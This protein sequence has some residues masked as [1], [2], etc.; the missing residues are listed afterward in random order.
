MIA[1]WHSLGFGLVT[2]GVLAVSSVGLTV[3]FGVIN[4]ANISY[5]QYMTL[6]A[7]FTWDLTNYAHLNIWIAGLLACI[8]VGLVSL[9]IGKAI[10]SQFV[11]RGSPGSHMLLV[12]FATA[13]LLSAIYSV[14]WGPSPRQLDIH[15]LNA[16]H[17]G[18]FLFT[19]VQLYVI[20]LSAGLLIAMHLVLT[21]TRLGKAMRA[22]SDNMTLARLTGIPTGRVTDAVWL[23]TGFLAG[24]GGVALAIEIASFDI[25]L[26]LNFFFVVMAAVVVGGIGKPYGTM[27]GA[28]LI[29]V[30]IEVSTN[31][32][33]AQY[34]LDVAFLILI[35]ILLWKPQ[36]ISR[37]TGKV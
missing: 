36:G 10:F 33:P 30:S 13:L 22:M 14:A 15:A 29:G 20:G 6:G 4:Y 37:I 7:Y 3:Q 5:G 17:V 24:V 23:I 21:R 28:L 1:F 32:I 27:V 26:G 11:K 19:A 16:L 2:A 35:L 31:V 9:F 18:P 12:T 25:N 8:G 34:K